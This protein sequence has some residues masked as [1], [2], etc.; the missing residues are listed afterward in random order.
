MTVTGMNL[1]KPGV[2]LIGQNSGISSNGGKSPALDF[3]ALISLISSGQAYETVK[4]EGLK[5]SFEGEKPTST[6]E[7]IKMMLS[8]AT[9]SE[10]STSEL[11]EIE[12]RN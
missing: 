11:S 12:I 5:N 7:L 10:E 6:E 1:S 2:N 3:A 9:F 4:A 8:S